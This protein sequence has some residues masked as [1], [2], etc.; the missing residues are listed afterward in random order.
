MKNIILA[1]LFLLL[2]LLL[3][4]SDSITNPNTPFALSDTVKIKYKETVHHEK[5]NISLTFNSLISDSRC[6]IG[7]LC[8][9]EGNAKIGF[10]FSNQNNSVNFSLHTYRNFTRDTTLLGYNI[11]LISV[12][13]YPHVDYS[14]SANQYQVEVVVVRE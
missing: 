12:S 8:V 11:K 13:P 6:P 14:Y 9:W 7:V 5:E 4:C 3:N 1:I 2:I 10:K